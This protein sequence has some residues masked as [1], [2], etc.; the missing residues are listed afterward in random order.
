MTQ[1][2]RQT[3]GGKLSEAGCD[4]KVWEKPAIQ[5]SDVSIE[6]ISHAGAIDDARQDSGS[7]S[8]SGDL[9][10]SITTNCDTLPRKGNESAGQRKTWLADVIR[11][12]V[13]D[14]GVRFGL[15]VGG[16]MLCSP[17]GPRKGSRKRRC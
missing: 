1:I 7:G 5:C 10:L 13:L 15:F 11:T 16:K 17:T 8:R 4:G 3:A 12:G 9:P 2:P 14:A 6:A